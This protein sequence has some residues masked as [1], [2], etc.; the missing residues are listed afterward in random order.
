MATI[1]FAGATETQI[2]VNIGHSGSTVNDF[3]LYCDGSL[4]ASGPITATTSYSSQ[5]TKTG[6][7]AGTSYFFSVYFYN[8]STQIG[9]AATGT[10]STDSPPPPPVPS[11]L[12]GLSV[13]VSGFAPNATVV[14]NWNSSSGATAY[15]WNAAGQSGSVQTPGRD[16]TVSTAGSYTFTVTPF[17]TTGNGSGQSQGFTV[18]NPTPPPSTPT[19][20]TASTR[21][22]TGTVV[23]DLSW[24]TSSGASSY[25]IFRSTTSGSGYSH[26]NSTS[27][28]SFTDTSIF[29][30]ITYYYVVTAVGAGGESGFSNQASA[31]Y[32]PPPPPPAP[33]G[34]HVTQTGSGLI[35]L[36]WNAVSTSPPTLGYRVGKSTTNGSGYDYTPFNIAETNYTFMGLSNGTTYYFVV[37]T[38]NDNGLSVNSNQVSAVPG[39][40]NFSWDLPKTQGQNLVITA[41]EWNRLMINIDQVRAEKG[42]AAVS[43]GGTVAV[44]DPVTA[45]SGVAGYNKVRQAIL[46]IPGRTVGIPSTATSGVTNISALMLNALQDSLNSV[47]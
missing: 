13:S 45:S 21:S 16:I 41:N 3:N 23:A 7:T 30:N 19:G 28:T 25:K 1:S 37:V 36:A 43:W 18:S 15:S 31:L 27:S 22:V 6:L 20:L 33:T 44:G 32:I 42:L 8:G 4:F 34:L 39:R 24:N 12:T 10:Y 9:A 5:R 40:T 46:D 11:P 29:A 14:A 26:I 17:N 38:V 35:S 2:T 47:P